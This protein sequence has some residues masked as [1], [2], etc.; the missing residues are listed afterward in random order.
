MRRY[1]ERAS[2]C[3]LLAENEPLPEVRFRYRIVARHYRE[4]ADRDE[5]NDKA[6]MVERLKMLKSSGSS[7]V[8]ARGL[9]LAMTA[10]IILILA[11]ASMIRP[12]LAYGSPA[13][14]TTSE[15]RAKFPK[16]HLVWVGTNHCWT[17]GTVA[18]HSRP[19]LAEVPVPTPRPVLAAE[20]VPSPRPVLAAESVPSPP[21]EPAAE[22]V[23]STRPEIVNSDIDAGAQCRYS[24]C[25]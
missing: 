17:F 25:E 3:E 5:R 2:E 12:S 18:V 4:L 7:R 6:K 13:C 1:R 15:A 19:S 22:P 11:V 21:P 24:P 9:A 14:M 16:A 10:R 20:P 8:G 23:P